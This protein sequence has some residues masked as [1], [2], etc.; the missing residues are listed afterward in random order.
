MKCINKFGLK[1]TLLKNLFQFFL[2]LCFTAYFN[3]NK[4]NSYLFLSFLN[5]ENAFFSSIIRFMLT[6]LL[7]L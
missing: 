5:R 1:V 6:A 2:K 3:T 4:K 7:I